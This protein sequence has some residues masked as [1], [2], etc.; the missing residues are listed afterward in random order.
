MCSCSPGRASKVGNCRAGAACINGGWRGP[1][2]RS[3]S[4]QKRWQ[5]V[6]TA[7]DAW[8]AQHLIISGLWPNSCS[9]LSAQCTLRQQHHH[10]RLACPFVL[11]AFWGN[12]DRYLTPD[13]TQRTDDA[14]F[15]ITTSRQQHE[16]M[17]FLNI[18]NY[19]Y[20]LFNIYVLYLHLL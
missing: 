6:I 1:A 14:H 20:Q 16:R 7:T 13:S 15:A 17:R 9:P 5:A 4:I 10:G 2:M 11:F 8:H 3:P 12:C 18:L 19:N